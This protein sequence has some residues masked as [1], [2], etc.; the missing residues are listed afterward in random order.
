MMKTKFFYALLSAL[1]VL[2]LAVPVF[3][4]SGNPWED[5]LAPVQ[6]QILTY[7]GYA[8]AAL[9]LLVAVPVGIKVSLHLAAW[10]VN[11]LLN[12]F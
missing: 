6:T 2:P 4:Q 5:W 1:V 12:M 7:V 10:G 3:A 9:F 8:I 11:K